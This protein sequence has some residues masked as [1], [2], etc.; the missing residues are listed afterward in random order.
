MNPV[1]VLVILL[2]AQSVV[3]L[4]IINR[5]VNKIMSRDYSSY[6]YDKQINYNEKKL[7]EVFE[8]R[9]DLGALDEFKL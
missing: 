3:F 2:I 5:L 1:D 8:D 6:Q 7:E 4:F 9:R